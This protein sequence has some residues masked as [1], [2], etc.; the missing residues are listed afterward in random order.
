MASNQQDQINR[1]EGSIVPN[2]KLF[3]IKEHCSES[4]LVMNQL[5]R[6]GQLCD[7]TFRIG[8]E[9]FSAHRVVVSSVSPYLRAMFTC[10]MK[11]SSQ[12]EVELRDIEPQAMTSLINY[13]YT[14]EVL[15]T[16]DNVQDLLPA[17]G[18]LQLKDLKEACCA[19]LSEHMETSNCLG[20]KQFADLHSCPDLLKKANRFI[21]RKFMDITAHEEFLQLP[22][23]VLK[24]ILSNDHLHV[25]SELHVYRAFIAWVNYDL[26][27]RAMS[28]FD[29]FDSVRVSL[30][31]YDFWL[32]AFREEP[33]FQKSQACYAFLKGYMMGV[34]YDTLD[35]DPR[36]PM[37]SIYTV[38]G[39]NSQQCLATAER[40][41]CEDNR[42]EELPVMKQ[43]R[44]AVAAGALGG[45]IYAVGGECETRFAREGTQYLTSVEYYD[46][47]HN[48][49]EN[50]ADMKH[51]RSFTAVCTLQGNY[52]GSGE[53]RRRRESTLPS[54]GPV[55]GEHPYTS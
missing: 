16:V 32:Q 1:S 47:I 46:P 44:T 14:G 11:E 45:K 23:S 20:I 9:T 39:R 33:V 8:T 31:P 37:Q 13:A 51:P 18:I 43:V 15:V 10:G 54:P 6:E 36:F 50:V 42:W 5:R 35:K 52:E 4:F 12:D 19:F 2:S 7:V 49:W 48:V 29:L 17:A 30:V 55:G 38:G 26:E 24:E 53:R 21:V 22:K 25:D 28:A 34:H 41:I 40:Y 3:K 27:A